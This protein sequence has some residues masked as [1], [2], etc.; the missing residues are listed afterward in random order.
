[1][2]TIV[3]GVLGATAAAWC[4]T[5]VATAQVKVESR[6]MEIVITG[7]LHTQWN[8]TSVDGPI[9]NEFLIRRARLTAEVEINELVSGK[10]QPDY[11]DGE[12]SLKDAYLR[13]SFDPAFRATI[14]QFKRPF[15]LFELTSSTQI[16]VIERAGGIRGL[17]ECSGPEGICSFSRFTERLEY[18][19]RDIGVLVDGI[20]ASGWRYMFSVTNGT[21]ANEADENGDKSFTG[22]VE[23]TP[24]ADLT[25]GANVA[26]H[27]FE[28][29]VDLDSERATAF[30]G[31]VEWGNFDR[32]LHIQAGV[33]AGDNWLNLDPLGDPSKFL[34]AQGIVTYKIPLDDVRF[35]E[36]I[37]PVGRLSWGDPDD[38]GDDDEGV[39]LTPGLVAFFSGR[40]KI[41]V[42][43][44][45]WMPAAGDTEVSFK[46]Q[47]YLHF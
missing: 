42:N 35:L 47:S 36:A 30:G 34:T 6:A 46:V 25:V 18:S 8:T 44:D 37:E 23:F 28:N 14:G 40:N 13:L 9:S 3:R 31:D 45:I 21:G 1:M 43:A 20:V 27:D 32:G 39:L 41:A 29:E 38:D 16:L 4:L 19:D 2:G 26:A 10:I 15:D 33:V 7:R 22:R 17:S 11:G 5:A 24:M 12:L